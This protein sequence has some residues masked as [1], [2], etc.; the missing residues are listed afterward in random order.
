MDVSEQP[1]GT[2]KRLGRYELL[3]QV[4]RGF[5]G[6]LWAARFDHQGTSLAALVRIVEPPPNASPELWEALSDAAWSAIDLQVP[7]V[8]HCADVVFQGSTLALV[9]DYVEG[10]PLSCLLRPKTNHDPAFPLGIA[11]RITLDALKALDELATGS[12][13]LGVEAVHGGVSADALLVGT[14]GMT[15]VLN[16]LV[17]AAAGNEE[18]FR[19]QPERAPYVSPEQWLQ[20]SVDGRTDVYAVGCILWELLTRKR[21]HAGSV[22][23][24]RRCATSARLPAP[25]L[26]ARAEALSAVVLAILRKALAPE[27][28]A[29]YANLQAFAEALENCSIELAPAS[30]VARFVETLAAAPLEQQ[31]AAT[32]NSTIAHLT[33]FFK[34]ERP[35]SVRPPADKP[36]VGVEPREEK[37]SKAAPIDK[38]QPK[39][40]LALKPLTAVNPKPAVNLALVPGPPPAKALVPA[41]KPHGKSV[42]PAPVAVKAVAPTAVGVLHKA[43]APVS[44]ASDGGRDARASAAPNRGQKLLKANATLL[45]ISPPAEVNQPQI[46]SA[47]R[48]I[49][50][51]APSVQSSPSAVTVPAPVGDELGYEEELTLP[52][53]DLLTALPLGARPA[54]PAEVPSYDAQGSPALAVP[55]PASFA[56]HAANDSLPEKAT[57]QLLVPARVSQPRVSEPLPVFPQGFDQTVSLAELRANAT[58]SSMPVA[59]PVS[60]GSMPVAVPV[61]AGSMANPAAAKAQWPAVTWFFMGCTVSLG[62]VVLVGLLRSMSA[63]DGAAVNGNVSGV[64]APQAMSVASGVTVPVAIA[65]AA[66]TPLVAAVA[67]SAPTAALPSISASS[68]VPSSPGPATSAPLAAAPSAP[69][70][71]GAAPGPTVSG[72]TPLVSAPVATPPLP[73][74]VRPQKRSKNNAKRTTPSGPSS[75]RSKYVPKDL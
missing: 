24:I 23:N 22:A 18:Y 65:P 21:L 47:P 63:P 2:N 58:A 52:Y 25:L 62:L 41:A 10:Q 48:A 32:E 20:K 30:D 29:R 60:A 9:D 61:S 56:A 28:A 8:V 5:L 68:A 37:G 33:D 31:R 39:P 42:A 50:Q 14:D 35:A 26:D 17:S 49:E 40:K 34:A 13:S 45:G 7:G 6:P 71:A 46:Q 72:A 64:V 59:A 12:V 36:N 73:P 74:A 57:Q 51:L 44:V 38:A 19:S 27:A 54:A 43:A 70:A 16:P 3:K 1:L 67:A 55:E 66:A 69:N 75:G 11:L 53:Q 15:R 4:D